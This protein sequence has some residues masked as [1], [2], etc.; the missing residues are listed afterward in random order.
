HLQHLTSAGLSSTDDGSSISN[1]AASD[2]TNHRDSDGIS[3]DSLEDLVEDE[4]VSFPPSTSTSVLVASSLLSSTVATKNVS[5][6]R[7]RA[8]SH[9]PTSRNVFSLH[10]NILCSIKDR[11]TLIGILSMLYAMFVSGMKFAV[12]SILMFVVDSLHNIFTVFVC[13]TAAWVVSHVTRP[14]YD[15]EAVPEDIDGASPLQLSYFMT[16]VDP[17]EV[18]VAFEPAEFC[19]VPES[20]PPTF[21]YSQPDSESSVFPYIFNLFVPTEPK[22][23]DELQPTGN[24]FVIPGV[25]I[26]GEPSTEPL[27]PILEGWGETFNVN[28]PLVR[29]SFLMES[30][31]C[32]SYH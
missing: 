10:E 16:I 19:H 4:S 9:L 29:K 22:P 28:A 13:G 23:V 27:P 21:V 17:N 11:P 7:A 5:G 2:A 15:Q 31:V 12:F 25:E 24:H 3:W 26:P 14:G 20:G 8:A 18:H 1:L 6:S 32:K 30:I